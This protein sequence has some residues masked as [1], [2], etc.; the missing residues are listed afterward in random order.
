M[1][2]EEIYIRSGGEGLAKG[3]IQLPHMDESEAKEK[4]EGK[5]REREGE[6]QSKSSEGSKGFGLVDSLKLE[7]CHV[8]QIFD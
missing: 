5:A 3:D 1:L 7:K 2:E 8:G 4:A 6:K